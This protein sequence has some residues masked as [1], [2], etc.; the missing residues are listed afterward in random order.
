MP[1]T[2]SFRFVTAEKSTVDVAV[3]V[4]GPTEK[5]PPAPAP[6]PTPQAI[7][8]TVGATNGGTDPGHPPHY[9]VVVT[10]TK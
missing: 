8:A 5:P 4:Y 6:P 1:R 7:S 10:I 3:S 2:R 9:N